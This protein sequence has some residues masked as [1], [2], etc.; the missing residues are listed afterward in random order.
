MLVKKTE[1]LPETLC[2]LPD[3]Q[4]IEK[5]NNLFCVHFH[6]DCVTETINIPT[7]QKQED[8]KKKVVFNFLFLLISC[9]CFH[10]VSR[11]ASLVSWSFAFFSEHLLQTNHLL[12]FIV[13]QLKIR[14]K[15]LH[16]SNSKSGLQTS[17]TSL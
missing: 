16:Q 9:Y 3:Q 12:Y 14:R 17:F 1:V 11:S 2:P 7:H 6:S 5:K 4:M 8:Y 13:S 10:A 15:L